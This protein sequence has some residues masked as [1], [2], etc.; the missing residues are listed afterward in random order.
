MKK[1]TVRKLHELSL[2]IFE[3]AKALNKEAGVLH[4]H[5]MYSRA[6]LLAHFCV[7]ELGKL[8]MIVGLIAKKKNDEEVDW[9]KVNKRFCSHTQK[10]GSQ[11][12]HT[13]A[14]ALDPDLCRDT[15]LNWLLDANK[16]IPE[17]YRKK[18]A[19]TYVD[20][21][22]GD[23]LSPLEVINESDSEKMLNYSSVCLLAHERSERLIN[24]LIYEREESTNN[25]NC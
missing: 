20:V 7:E 14:F 2:A 8:P 15:D 25:E 17:T 19:S 9:K 5:E 3:N 18:N 12:G 22:N 16:E 4:E 13:Y 10:I 1:L 24:P 21:E 23:I 11:N 6:Y